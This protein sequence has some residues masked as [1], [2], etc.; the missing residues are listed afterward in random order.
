[1]RLINTKSNGPLLISQQAIQVLDKNS[2]ETQRTIPLPYDRTKE[3]DAVSKLAKLPCYTIP[4]RVSSTPDTS[5]I[6][7]AVEPADHSIMFVINGSNLRIQTMEWPKR[8]W[9]F[10]IGYKGQ[11]FQTSIGTW[12]W[13]GGPGRVDERSVCD[14]CG[15]LDVLSP[16]NIMVYRGRDVLVM[17]W[18]GELV[19]HTPV[20]GTRDAFGADYPGKRFALLLSK[21]GGLLQP[22]PYF[23]PTVFD[24]EKKGVMQLPHLRVTANDDSLGN[25]IAMS[26]DGSRVAV[27]AQGQLA[28]Y[29]ISRKGLR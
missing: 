21:G 3:N 1:M 10:A 12:S 17:R 8:I 4:L 11:F 7:V 23:V 9:D 13:A 5:R 22:P 2:L 6:E 26:E 28:L 20:S 24:I 15:H 25:A 19:W 14:E 27:F 16:D 18:D 29:D